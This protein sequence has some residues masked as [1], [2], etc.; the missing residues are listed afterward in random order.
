MGTLP[1]ISSGSSATATGGKVG[2]T[3]FGAVNIGVQSSTIWI[4]SAI[5]GVVALV[6]FFRKS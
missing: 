2:P 5:A 1:S 4:V 6:F 3:T